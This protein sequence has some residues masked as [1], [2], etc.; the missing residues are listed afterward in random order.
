MTIMQ[1]ALHSFGGDWSWVP[2]RANTIGPREILGARHRS[3]WL[4]GDLGGGVSW[5]RFIARLVAHGPVSEF[6]PGSILQTARDRLHDPRRRRRRRRDPHGLKLAVTYGAERDGTAVDPH[7]RRLAGRA[8]ADR[9]GHPGLGDRARLGRLERRPR[10]RGG[11]PRRGR[12]AGAAPPAGRGGVARQAGALAD[13]GAGAR[14]R[15]PARPRARCPAVLAVDEER[16][17]FA[18]AKAP[19]FVAQ[20]EGAAPRRRRPTRTS[21]CSSAGCSPPSTRRRRATQA[22]LESLRRRRGVRA[23]PGRAVPPDGRCGAG[24]SWSGAIGAVVEEMLDRRLCL[25]HGD[26]SP[27]NVLVGD[28][29]ALWL[30]DFEVAH[31]GDPA[32][33]LGVH[34]QPPDAEGDPPA[35]RVRALRA[36][37][38][39]L[40]GFLRARRSAVELAPDPTYVV[41]HTGCLMLARVDGKSPAEYLTESERLLARSL[42]DAPPA[43]AAGHASRPP[44]T[45]S[46]EALR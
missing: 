19:D 14:A 16:C 38:L 26:F 43:R 8:R 25:V 3:F 5:Q 35:G 4:D 31:A 13:R 22:V 20:L 28:G 24:R 33:D 17:A 41:L 12:Q 36:R 29:G 15:C 37:G 11:G 40:L 39:R 34:A 1:N 21:A 44:G 9:A 46:E 6:V 7:R 18:I 27:K 23:A 10:G 32:F 42:G 45:R 30:I 2:P